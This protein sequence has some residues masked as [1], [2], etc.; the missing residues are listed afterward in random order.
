MTPFNFEKDTWIYLLF[1]FWGG[2]ANYVATI[3]KGKRKFS[4]PE[5]VGELVI[6]GFSGSLAYA[7][8]RSYGLD[9][10]ITAAVTGIG[11]HFGSRTIFLLERYIIEKYLNVGKD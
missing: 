11:G 10:S 8:C 3:R 9:D 6:A 4:V 7:V 2:L 5:A 1:A